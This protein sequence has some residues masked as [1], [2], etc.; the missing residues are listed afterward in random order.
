MRLLF[1]FRSKFLLAATATASR[2]SISA[3]RCCSRRM[4]DVETDLLAGDDDDALTSAT[5][6][7]W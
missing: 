7:S 1:L 3:S 2:A 6:V 5:C 4:S